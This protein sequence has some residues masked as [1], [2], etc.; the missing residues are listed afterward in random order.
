[1]VSRRRPN[2]VTPILGTVE[3]TMTRKL[4]LD[5][6]TRSHLNIKDAGTDR[7]GRDASTEVLMLA[8]AFDDG[9]VSIWLPVLGEPMPAALH[10]G[11]TDPECQKF[12]W[13]YRFERG[14]FTHKL[15]YE[16]KRGEWFDPAVLA[17]YLSLPIGLDRASRALQIDE[18]AKKIVTKGDDRL[19]KIFSQLSKTKKTLMKKD[20][21]LPEFYYKDWTTN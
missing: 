18:T 8:W 4:W 10:E 6:E 17:G 19:T 13:N 14:I 1:M 2:G 16:T 11:M 3:N 7:Y 9:D 12:A 15:G 21:M 5:F 20:P